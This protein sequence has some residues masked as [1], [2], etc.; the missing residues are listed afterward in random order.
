MG[1]SST[2][3]ATDAAGKKTRL[4]GMSQPV[5]TSVKRLKE[6]EAPLFATLVVDAE[7]DFNWIRPHYGIHHSIANMLNLS[8]FQ[9]IAKSYEAYPAYL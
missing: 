8:Q 3:L 2:P 4:E 7:E 5:F 9:E 6:T 1:A